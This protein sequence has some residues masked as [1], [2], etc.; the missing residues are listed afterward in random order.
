M[1]LESRQVYRGKSFLKTK[2][3]P[4]Q[5]NKESRI[6]SSPKFKVMAIR[7][8]F[9]LHIQDFD[10]ALKSGKLRIPFSKTFGL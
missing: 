10:G 4:L 5:S 1:K 2:D 7:M 9:C 6:F 3:D 8:G